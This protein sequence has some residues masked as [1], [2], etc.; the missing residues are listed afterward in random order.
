MTVVPPTLTRLRRIALAALLLILAVTTLSAYM[1][2]ANAG[3]GCADWPACYGA[4]LRTPDA[5]IAA[6]DTSVAIA[7]VLHRLAAM[8]AQLADK[9]L[10]QHRAQLALVKAMA[11]V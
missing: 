1:R 10:R 2:L 7:R 5:A 3:L 6:S 9:P 11:S 4:Q 8:V